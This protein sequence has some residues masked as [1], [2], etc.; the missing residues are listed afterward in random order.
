MKKYLRY[1]AAVGILSIAA[2]A[3]GG[4]T[5]A[6]TGPTGGP[7]QEI[8]P[9]GTLKLALSS[10]VFNV[11]DPQKEYYSI[12]WEFLRCCFV[13][14]L[15]SYNARPTAEDGTV[16]FPDLAAE[17]PVV[18]EDQLTWT[19]TLKTG[20]SF[21]D[22]IN[23]EIVAEDFVTAINRI[24]DPEGSA[25][26][27]SFYYSPIEGFDD[28]Y[29]SDKIN[30]VSG[31]VA[32]DDQTLEFHLT[33]PTGD[34]GY[35]LAMPAGS[36]V[37]AEAAEGH[38]RDYGQFMVSSGPYQYEGMADVD[39]SLDPKRQEP[40][41]GVDP[42]KSYVLERNPAWSADT[43]SLRK[44]YVDR[45]EVQI[46]GE[47]QDLLDKVKAGEIDL[48]FD[49]GALP[50]TITEYQADPVLAERMK[51][52]ANDAISYSSMNVAVPPFDDV[53]VR[54]AMN[55]VLDKEAIRRVIGGAINGEIAGHAFVD[56]LL[57]NL[58]ADYHP[59]DSPDNRGDVAAAM[60]ELKL[61]T[62]YDTDGDGL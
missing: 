42:G 1:V 10:D 54:K 20:V 34:L 24:A 62:A 57:G 14:T 28:A 2:A 15:Q 52:F 33:E 19:Y 32:V 17:D 16:L 7:S 23:R 59:Y 60:E 27:Y 4:G 18:S 58:L 41:T 5:T 13:R 36:P 53:H 31:V 22:P 40:P 3:C 11:F 26:G 38:I 8:V 9:G 43:D 30:E 46:G 47:V 51:V 50:E 56:S 21:G 45:I 6:T 37:P 49:C 25:G 35:R 55:L 44:A 29:N 48:C 61:A 39:F 12:S